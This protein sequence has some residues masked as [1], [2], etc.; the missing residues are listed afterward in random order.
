MGRVAIALLS[1][2]VLVP[3]MTIR[4]QENAP[5][6][7]I[8]P[9]KTVVVD[10]KATSKSVIAIPPATIQKSNLVNNR[11]GGSGTDLTSWI[12]KEEEANGLHSKGLA[13]W[14][15][16]VTY[17][18]FDEDGDNVHSGTFEEYWAGNRDYKL[19]FK[20]DDFNQ[21]DYATDK[22]LFRLGDQ[23]WPD[24]AHSQVRS[25]TID[26]FSYAETLTGS[27]ITRVDR[28][29]SR[30]AF[31]CFA[32][33]G[34]LGQLGD[35]PQYCFEPDTSILR[36]TRGSGWFQTVYNDI[37]PFQG[38]NLAR[39]VDVTNGGKPYLKLRVTTVEL[40]PRVGDG[41]FVPPPEAV[42]PVGGRIS[43]VQLTTIRMAYPQWPS[44]MRGQHISV[45]VE[46]VVGKDG[47]VLSARG[48]SGLVDGYKAC[49]DAMKQWVFAPYLV[50]GNPVEVEAKME[51]RNY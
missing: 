41:F 29:F 45:T 18:Q 4:A 51:C 47:R 2:L 30:H 13:P 22:G 10:R 11:P 28:K 25:E 39:E 1:V 8:G 36:Y 34:S 26:P 31:Q 14:H 19:M 12:S 40:M 16:V 46:V 23:R 35:P 44:S 3:L 48:I 27:Q 9:L 49:E 33:E 50:L 32:I 42:G 15:I 21:T 37:V 5:A 6:N 7:Q 24:V 20:S 43:G 38:R 17:D